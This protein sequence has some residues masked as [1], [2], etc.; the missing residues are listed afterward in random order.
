[1]DISLKAIY[2]E[3]KHFQIYIPWSP[4]FIQNSQ[5]MFSAYEIA[6]LTVL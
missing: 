6:D 4:L 5:F 1:M 2:S 3:F